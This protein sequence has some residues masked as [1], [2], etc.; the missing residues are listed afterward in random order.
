MGDRQNS[1]VF[2]ASVLGETRFQQLCRR[3]GGDGETLMV[4]RRLIEAYAQPHRAYHAVTHLQDCLQ[5]FDRAKAEAT[6]PDEVEAALWFHD[7]VYD[8]QAA[9]NEARSAIWAI[10][11]LQELRIQPVV[12]DRIAAMVLLTKHDQKPDRQDDE[13][14]LDVDLSILG[15]NVDVFA[16]YERGIR[17]E[18]SWVNETQYCVKRTAILKR[19]LDRPT[20][21]HTQFFQNH[22]EARARKNLTQSIQRLQERIA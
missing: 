22:F 4:Y 18:Y 11:S 12:A 10:Q 15:Q 5:Q 20:I 3:L 21:Y 16:E 7:V 2:L 19:F 13:L 9:D 8:P 17:A 14:L 6:N 1:S